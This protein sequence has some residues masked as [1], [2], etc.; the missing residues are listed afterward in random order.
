MP[1]SIVN[2]GVL[3]RATYRVLAYLMAVE[4]VIQAA[5]IAF[6]VFGL[7]K[8]I[9]DGGVLDK[10]TQESQSES[11]TG[12]VGFAVHGINGQIVVP[13]IALLLLI[14]SFFA[15]VPRGVMLAGVVFLLVVIQVLLGIFGSSVPFLGLLHGL[16]AML[17]FGV[18]VSA[19]IAA[20]RGVP[21]P[22]SP[23]RAAA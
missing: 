17:L 21:T 11:F 18:A 4:V 7:S 16:N 9:D 6:A 14:V 2:L 8:W 12:V 19:A 22:A 1:G 20:G 10:A 5:A 15:K 23:A 3:M 13:L